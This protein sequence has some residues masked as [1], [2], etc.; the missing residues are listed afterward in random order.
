LTDGPILS[1]GS[2]TTRSGRG[3]RVCVITRLTTQNAGNEALSSL[4]LAFVA[5]RLPHADVRVLDRA[6]ARFQQ[7][8]LVRLGTSPQEILEAFELYARRLA[9]LAKPDAPL[10]AQARSDS[11]VF[12]R[13]ARA[14]SQWLTAFRH[15]IGFRRH[16]ARAGLYQ[17]SAYPE[18]LNT[19]AWSDLVIWN[20]AGELHP[21]GN[22]D[23]AFRLLLLVRVAQLLGRR[24][25]V[26]NHSLEVTHH[27]LSLLIRHVYA[28]ADFVAVREPGSYRTAVA[29]GL[30]PS[31]LAEIPDLVFL[32]ATAEADRPPA[33]A[34]AFA[35]GAIAL[36]LNGREA[37][38]GYDEWEW[39]FGALEKL[40]RPLIVL[41]N[42]LHVDLPFARQYAKEH[43][44]TLFDR[45][46]SSIEL[47]ELYSRCDAV[48]T[49]RL[50]AALFGLAAG[51]P[52][53]TIE[54]QLH[55]LTAIF[56]RLSYPL[57]TDTLT[58]P[59]W[60]RRI[61]RRT[62]VALQDGSR[63]ID[64]GTRGILEQINRIEVSYAPLFG[65]VHPD[66]HRPRGSVEPR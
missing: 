62:A 65:L 48:I 6:P 1:N 30:T 52:V 56:E 17:S 66:R 26:I 28:R 22:V 57:S 53:I 25:A 44:L 42:A 49:S 9:A 34:S 31:Q 23:D 29:M 11:V 59:G 19:V 47:V 8:R 41:S 10:A 43:G 14:P 18:A 24:T 63:F 4:L 2:P 64:S 16:L 46:P 37:H 60:S 12:D 15:S 20:P 39:L 13:T 38:R 27:P 51:V 61:V 45:Q 36:A 50:H 58:V 5:R 32:I 21:N 55:K 33:P 40:G 35:P 7:F 54:P 3:P